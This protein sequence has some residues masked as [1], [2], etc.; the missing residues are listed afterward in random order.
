MSQPLHAVSDALVEHMSHASIGVKHHSTMTV[1]EK[2]T[3]ITRNLQEVLGAESIREV[4]GERPLR[5][6]WG[7]ATTGKPHIGYLVPMSKIADFLKAGC[8]VKILL[9]DLHAFLDNQKAPWPLLRRRTTYYEQVIKATLESIGV[10]TEQLE[11]VVGTSYQLSREYNL[12]AYR[13]AAMVTEHDAKKAGAEVVK[14]VDHP[15]LS[16]LI[17]PGLQALDEEYLGVDAQ[18][19]GTDQRKIF[20]YAEK[21]L[22]QLGYKKRSH[23][24]NFMVPGLM[25]SKMSS[26]DPDS[27]ID[28][29]DDRATVERKIKKSFCEE[30][31]VKENGL[32]SFARFVL[33]PVL[34]LRGQPQ[35]QLRRKAE[36]GGDLTFAHYQELEDCFAQRQL[37]PGDLKKG[38]A[39]AINDLLEP[40]RQRWAKDPTLQQLTA[41]AYPSTPS[42]QSHP[43]LSKT[44]M[45]ATATATA[46]DITRFDLR[47]GK[48]VSIERHPDSESLYVEQIE[49]GE[50]RPRTV[51]SGLVKFYS[52]E[53]LLNRSIILFAN[54]KPSKFRGILSEGMVLAASQGDRVEVLEPPV[55]SV[56]GERVMVD[57]YSAPQTGGVVHAKQKFYHQVFA[58]LK[59]NADGVATYKGAVLKTS[60]GPVTASSLVEAQIG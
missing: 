28:L 56:I 14:Q 37:H 50:A 19:G 43:K 30:G 21:Y 20:T 16:G 36:F 55:E 12:D 7:T 29:L 38:V 58:E 45:P 27:K 52:I 13:L 23:L 42:T 1:E 57:G 48:I 5:M 3:L 41:E 59:T 17:Y 53:Q 10:S 44:V 9:A 34:A 22:P 11:F 54:L 31:N 24:M 33:F 60:Q 15:L 47:V 49:V 39:D 4:L 2:Y 32:L 6:Y 40:I 25:G 35:F 26:S 51:V 8:H 46:E 18:F